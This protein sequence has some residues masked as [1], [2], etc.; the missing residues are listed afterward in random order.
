MNDLQGYG[1]SVVVEV[2]ASKQAMEK[3]RFHRYRFVFPA[4]PQAR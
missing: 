2:T 4:V 3:G 1:L